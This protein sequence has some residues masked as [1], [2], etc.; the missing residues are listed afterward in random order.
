MVL[1]KSMI[2]CFSNSNIPRLLH[3]L[4]DLLAIEYRNTPEDPNSPFDRV[5]RAFCSLLD[6][7]GLYAPR[8]SG[9]PLDAIPAGKPGRLR[10]TEPPE[11][12]ETPDLAELG[13]L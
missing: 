9:L 12:L 3:M 5:T 10:L 2:L 8:V 7:R 1:A 13:I 4:I 6:K 11:P